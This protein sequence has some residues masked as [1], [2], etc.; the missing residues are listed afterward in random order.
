ME[1]F[2]ETAY[3]EALKAYKNDEIPVGA[4]V[5]K[6]NRVISKAH[7]DRQKRSNVLGHAEINA[8]VK[9]AKRQKD[10]RLDG[11]VLYVTLEPCDMCRA[12][13]KESRIEKV[14]YLLEQ[15]K[16]KTAD[17]QNKC[18]LTMN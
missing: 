10:W 14:Y 8:I 12:I 17:H 13:I 4:V 7:N 15:K 11:Y 6:N 3:K 18:T 2:M 9:A 16:I 5:V 1:N